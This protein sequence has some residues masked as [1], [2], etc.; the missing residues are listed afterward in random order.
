MKKSSLIGH[1]TELFELIRPLKHP[2]DSIVQEFFRNRHYLGSK[3]R[4]FISEVIYGILRNYRLLRVYVEE[5]MKSVELEVLPSIGL[6][7]AFALRMHNEQREAV[8][9]DTES[10]WKIFF[11]KADVRSFVDTVAEAQLPETIRLDNAKRIAVLYSFPDSIV[12]SWIRQFGQE[13]TESLCR[14]LNEPA[15]TVIRVNSLKTTVEECRQA[16]RQEGIETERTKLSPVGLVLTKRI[17]AQ[18]LKSYKEGWFEMQDEGSQL[19]SLL[20]QPTPG[21]TIVDAC[22]GGGGKT[23]HLAALMNN[24][25]T[26][27]LVDIDETRLTNIRPRLVRAGVTI[28]QLHNANRN[29]DKIKSLEGMADSVLVDAPCSGTGTFRRNPAAKLGFSDEFVVRSA[30][31]QLAVLESYSSLVKPS[32]RLVYTTCTLLRQE[33]EDIVAEFLKNHPEFKVVSAPEVLGQSRI[34]ID[35]SSDFMTLLPH[36]TGTDGFF[37]A[38]MIRV[39]QLN[40]AH[41]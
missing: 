3:D 12:E 23:L 21:Q 8:L 11:P 33:N 37:A 39:E 28:A 20:L 24:D 19:L 27:H 18:S 7:I 35:A 31:T 5:G 25:G 32:G 17:N 41:P 4:R 38:V 6:Y 30:K 36:K 16:L 22:A 14:S 34:P 1:V 29:I 9:S 26:L 10:H 2:A 15:A 13:E 40:A